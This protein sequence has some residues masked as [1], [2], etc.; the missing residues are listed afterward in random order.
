VTKY[1]PL[2][3]HE[4]SVLLE[5]GEP[6]VVEIRTTG[7]RFFVS[8]RAN[9]IFFHRNGASATVQLGYS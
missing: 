4:F 7:Q 3:L 8:V 5:W 1:F 6:L 9:V 2:K